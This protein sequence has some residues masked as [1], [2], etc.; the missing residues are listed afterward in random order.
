M[1][2]PL[3]GVA[4]VAR[5]LKTPARSVIVQ[6]GTEPAVRAMALS[7]STG[8]SKSP[9]DTARVCG[10]DTQTF[11]GS[12]VGAPDGALLGKGV[13]AGDGE[14]VGEPVGASVGVAVGVLVKGACVG[15]PDGA[16]VGEVVGLG[17][18]A[19]VSPRLVGALVGESVAS[20]TRPPHC[21]G[22]IS[23]ITLSKRAWS[24]PLRR[25]M[26]MGRPRA[27]EPLEDTKVTDTEPE[28]GTVALAEKACTTSVVLSNR[29]LLLVSAAISTTKPGNGRSERA[30]TSTVRR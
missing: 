1:L 27:L 6:D 2:A 28:T 20:P 19:R 7:A 16:L 21:D 9:L 26:M 25:T 11:F 8:N 10:K 4:E 5:G 23:I 18:G 24:P 22:A 13:G 30:S 14:F 12:T 3:L 17:L 15:D 29:P